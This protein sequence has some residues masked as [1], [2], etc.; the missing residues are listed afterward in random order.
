M[1]WWQLR[2]L[3]WSYLGKDN[4]LKKR[5]PGMSESKLQPTPGDVQSIA[6]QKLS[7]GSEAHQG[8]TASFR[9]GERL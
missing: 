1:V 5:L 9:W 6:E 2:L 4:L 3:T 8:P 7:E